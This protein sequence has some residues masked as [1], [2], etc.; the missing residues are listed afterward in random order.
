MTLIRKSSNIID[1][2][3]QFPV[4]KGFK[5]CQLA[6]FL[7]PSG[8]LVRQ[9]VHFQYSQNQSQILT[10]GG[11]NRL[12]FSSSDRHIH[13]NILFSIVVFIIVLDVR[14]CLI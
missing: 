14:P 1:T 3:L 10:N 2:C 9:S 8:L 4:F 13:I 6:R 11:H 7:F 12:I 5:G